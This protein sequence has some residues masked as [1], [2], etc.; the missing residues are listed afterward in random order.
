MPLNKLTGVRAILFALALLPFALRAQRADHFAAVDSFLSAQIQ[1]GSVSGAVALCW[2]RGQEAYVFTGGD[3]DIAG[4]RPMQ[5]NTIFR[6]A[7][8]TK[9]IVSVACLRLVE[10]GR[11]QLDDPLQRYLPEYADMRVLFRGLSGKDTLGTLD[12][13][14][15][16]RHL[17][18]HTSGISSPDEYPQ[19]A[20]YYREAGIGFGLG[21]GFRT[22]EEE[23]RALAKIPLMHQPGDRFSYGNSTD[24]LA[25]V[26]EVASGQPLDRLLK[27]LVFRPVGM[28]DTYFYLPRSKATRLATLYTGTSSLI[29][30]ANNQAFDPDYPT[31]TKGTFF[32]GNGGLVSTPDDYLRFLVSLLTDERLLKRSTF[33]EFISNQIGDKTFIFGGRSSVNPFGLGVAITSEKGIINNGASVGSFFWGGAFNTAFLADPSKQRIT[34]LFFQHY[35]FIHSGLLSQYERLVNKAMDEKNKVE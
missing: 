28:K 34:L 7:S 10:R 2:E 13:P 6:L 17:L 8:M 12:R 23:V 31:N 5:R 11:I 1:S 9:A 19:Y 24:V 3:A 22:L 35:P 25:R 30:V 26:L 16:V 15:T 4:K 21:A 33:Q 20:A 14:I 32:S 29:Q 18:T 27:Q